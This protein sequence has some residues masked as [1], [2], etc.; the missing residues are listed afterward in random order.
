M[1][2]IQ[3]YLNYFTS[4]KFFLSL[5]GKTIYQ[6]TLR[7][8]L[9]T[10]FFGA[11]LLWIPALSN[12]DGIYIIDAFFISISAFTNTGLTTETTSSKFTFFGQL[13][14][15]ILIQLGG[16]GFITAIICLWS[17]IAKG[18]NLNAESRWFLHF[19]RGSYN[20]VESTQSF[21]AGV[22]VLLVTEAI[23]AFLLTIFFFCATPDA[24]AKETLNFKG[25]FFKS[26]WA[27][28]FHSISAANNAGF[29]ILGEHSIMPYR[30]GANNILS[31]I[32]LIESVIGGIGYPIYYD[33]YLLYKNKQRGKHHQLS[34][35]TIIC[36]STY[37]FVA[38]LSTFLVLFFEVGFGRDYPTGTIIYPND[39]TR[40]KDKFVW[41]DADKMWNIVYTSFSARSAGF[42]SLDVG[43]VTEETKWLLSI[44]MFVGTSPASTGG[45]IRTI[46]IFLILAKIW[47]TIKGKNHLTI[48]NKTVDPE[49]IFD[50]CQAFVVATILIIGC[51]FLIFLSLNKK[52]LKIG[53]VAFEASSAFGTTGLTANVTKECNF[54]GKI[55][56][57]FLMF[58][59]QL[60]VSNSLLSFTDLQPKGKNIR[61]C[62]ENLKII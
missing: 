15:L 47:F 48:R 27:G 52:N 36:L 61:Y 25:D 46:T 38:F 62:A 8:Y 45:G 53:D 54:F 28:I 26:L 9:F 23:G 3:E 59:G 22:I 32:L 11:I 60:G 20:R 40:A 7:I 1:H 17:W 12:K 6:K 19:E 50:A 2:N 56:I 44:L 41:N 4:K 16:I 35:F 21:K 37:F 42:S 33:L 5:L 18:G 51:I 30:S 58:I 13:V 55:V 31:V 57:I 43:Q 24:T 34:L 14:I 29:D 10:A 49:I 39:A